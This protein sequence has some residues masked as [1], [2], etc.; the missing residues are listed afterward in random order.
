LRGRLVVTTVGEGVVLVV[1]E[2]EIGVV[3]GA[4]LSALEEGVEVVEVVVWT[5][6][7]MLEEDVETVDVV[8]GTAPSTLEAG[9]ELSDIVV[10]MALSMLEEGTEDVEVVVGATPSTPEEDVEVVDVVDGTSTGLDVVLSTT[11]VDN[12]EVVDG[13]DV[14]LVLV[15]STTTVDDTDVV[16]GS[17]DGVSE[18]VSL[19]KEVGVVNDGKGSLVLASEGVDDGSVTVLVASVVEL[20][21]DVALPGCWKGEPVPFQYRPRA[22]GPPHIC[23]ASPVHAMLQ[24]SAG[25]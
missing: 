5:V 8:V 7:S 13:I 21:T 14:A 10:W 12:S 25:I 16:R 15:P 6:L 22:L 2:L 9:V 11:I 20:V 18:L 4:A 17:D 1:V 3:V 23:D 19:V 24:D